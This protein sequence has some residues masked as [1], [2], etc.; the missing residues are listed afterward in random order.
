MKKLLIILFIG[1]AVISCKSDKKNNNSTTEKTE[2]HH[3]KK[4]NEE[5]NEHEENEHNKEIKIVLIDGK[6][7]KVDKPM[8]LLIQNIRTDVMDFNGNTLDDYKV[9]ADKINT[10]LEVLTSS[11][12]MTG[13]AHDELHKW[14]VPFLG[15]AETFSDSKTLDQAQSSYKTLKNSFTLVDQNFE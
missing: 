2:E 11:C 3:E 5:H 15:M 9:L 4:H 13:Q 7:W 8:M 10:N 14:L 1:L 6:K 12:T